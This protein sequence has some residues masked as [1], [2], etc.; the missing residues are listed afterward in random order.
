MAMTPRSRTRASAVSSR[1]LGGPARLILI[2]DTCWVTNQ[3][4][5]LIKLTVLANSPCSKVSSKTSAANNSARGARPSA[6]GSLPAIMEA[7]AVP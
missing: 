1:R 5:A 2:T 3:L 6:K 7:M 4:S